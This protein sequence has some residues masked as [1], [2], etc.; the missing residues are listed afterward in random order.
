VLPPVDCNDR[1]AAIRPGAH[2]VA[3]NGID[4]NCNGR[5]ARARIRATIGHAWS[6]IGRRTRI[7]RLLVRGAPP[8]A[9]V[10]VSC[11]RKARGCKVKRAR[12]RVGRRRV[13]S[14]KAML[15]RSRLRTGAVV[16]IR[17]TAPGATGRYVRYR[18]RTGKIPRLTERCLPPGST[19]P[20]RCG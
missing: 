7:V 20:T 11:G 2:D 19:K 1:N 6:V 16:A 5:D 9:T 13:V 17:V 4:E 12:R 3:G 14:V 8:A 15:R 18:V 10:H